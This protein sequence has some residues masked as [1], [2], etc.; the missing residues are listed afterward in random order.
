MLIHFYSII[1]PLLLALPPVASIQEQW[2]VLASLLLVWYSQ[3]LLLPCRSHLIHW[4]CPFLKIQLI[5]VP[6]SLIFVFPFLTPSFTLITGPRIDYHTT[7]RISTIGFNLMNN[8]MKKG[9][10]PSVQFSQDFFTLLVFLTLSIAWN[11]LPN[12]ETLRIAK[13]K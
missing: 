1:H 10:F 7:N 8:C 11:R 4:S 13:D 3:S 9:C 12:K 2:R 5:C 6:L